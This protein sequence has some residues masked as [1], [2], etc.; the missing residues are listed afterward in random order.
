MLIR[1]AL[2]FLSVMVVVTMAIN[3]YMFIITYKLSNTHGIFDKLDVVQ[4][5][6]VFQN[7]G[8]CA[9]AMLISFILLGFMLVMILK[10]FL[11]KSKE[12]FYLEETQE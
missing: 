12:T 6:N 5:Y 4:K 7:L 2:I 10:S 11:N 9:W 1:I 3:I 8:M